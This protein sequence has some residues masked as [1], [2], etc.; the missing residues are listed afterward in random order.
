M[1][2]SNWYRWTRTKK[3]LMGACYL[4]GFILAFCMEEGGNAYGYWGLGF[5]FAGALIME[6]IR[7]NEW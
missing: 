6:T 3:R 4:I 7:H 1:R 2:V 5:M